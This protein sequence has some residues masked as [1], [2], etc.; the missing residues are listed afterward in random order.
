M[1][2]PPRRLAVC[3]TETGFFTGETTIAVTKQ[4]TVWM[5]A[6][7]WEW[8]LARSNDKGRHWTAYTVPGPQAFPGCGVG[9]SAVTNCDESEQ[10]KYN[11]VADAFLWADPRTS[12]LFWSKTYGYAAC[13]SLNFTP[14]NG[15]SWHAVTRFAC[16]GGDYEKIAGGPPPAGGA[17]PV[18][19]PD[20]LYGCTNGPAPTFVVGPGRICYK[21]LDGGLSWSAAGQPLPSPLAP[22]CLQFQEPQQV[23]PDG[24]LYLP[25]NCA[26]LAS[27][28]AGLVKVAISHDEGLTWSY[29]SVPTGNAGSDAGLIGGVSLAVDRAG[30]LYV[31]W[32]GADDKPY[33]A[34]SR[35]GGRTWRGP[36]MV[37]MPGVVEAAPFAQIAALESGHVAIA[38]YGHSA[39]GSGRRL[40]GYLTESFDAA[41]VK[42]TF[43]SA[44]LNDS[45]HP[46]YFPVKS[47]TLP[48]NDYLGV[49]IAPDGTPWT[50]LVKLRSATP[51]AQGYIP[52]TGFVARLVPIPP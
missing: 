13:S 43:Y 46:L 22:G 31:L 7:N 15:R 37:G 14:S 48:R 18:G 41:A 3:A 35:N 11:T 40:N 32:P 8:A 23:G 33:L 21:S 5:S 16:P 27:N 26:T 17:K 28:P 39:Q 38:Y 9:T 34:V 12:R 36:S 30:A 49:T 6:A 52:S 50:G 2:K 10:A 24:T 44:Q 47:G 42:P 45:R 19:Y 51:D 1:P 4:G 25:L 29:T 20:V